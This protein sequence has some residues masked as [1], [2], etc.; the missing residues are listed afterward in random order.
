MS[1][2]IGWLFCLKATLVFLLAI[3]TLPESR[4]LHHCAIIE[5]VQLDL[6]VMS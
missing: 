1:K 4:H 3:I 6:T 5:Q 2:V